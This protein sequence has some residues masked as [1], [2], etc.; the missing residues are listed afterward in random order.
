MLTF[1][2]RIRKGFLGSGQAQKY[3]LYAIGE[4]LLVMIGILLALQV[5]NWNNKRQDI[6]KER[7]ILNGIKKVF[8]QNLVELLNRDYPKINEAYEVSIELLGYIGPSPSNLST[9]TLDSLLYPILS[10]SSYYP[11]T[12]VIDELLYS[13]Q[14]SL[15]RNIDLR[16]HLSNWPGMMEDYNE[17]INISFNYQQGQILP[18][19]GHYINWKNTD[20]FLKNV[21]F[22]ELGL[23][24]LTKSKF[25][26]T[27]EEFLSSNEVE[28]LIY[29]NSVNLAYLM[30][31]YNNI[32]NYFEEALKMIE[33]SLAK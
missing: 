7:L 6:E 28:N 9:H 27:Y 17:D 1:F 24:K 14:L 31:E 29:L 15:I 4:M 5:N 23:N 32:H 16:N 21:E 30:T 25:S 26:K 8:E 22:R 3:L 18:R 10:M 11:S 2:R 20:Q 12:G 33:E 13:G 19:L